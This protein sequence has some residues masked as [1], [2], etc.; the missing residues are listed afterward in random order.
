MKRA[1]LGRRTRQYNP[2]SPGARTL[3]Q[4]VTAVLALHGESNAMD[5]TDAVALVHATPP[6][7]RSRFAR[8]IWRIRREHG[9]GRWVSG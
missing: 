3:A 2:D 5:T 6:E 1:G 8:E 4:W 7:Q 9:T